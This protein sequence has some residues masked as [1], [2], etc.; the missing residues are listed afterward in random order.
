MRVRAAN[1]S[2]YVV[3]VVTPRAQIASNEPEQIKESVQEAIDKRTTEGWEL[4]SVA[5]HFE[6]FQGFQGPEYLL[7]FRK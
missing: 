7:V 6:T 5:V 1:T 3:D 2:H 4:Q